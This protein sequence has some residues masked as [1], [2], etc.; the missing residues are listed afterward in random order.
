[1]VDFAA[2]DR[3][4]QGL[5]GRE[6]AIEGADADAGAAR[7]RLEARVRA[8][9]AEHRFRCLEHPLAIANRIGARPSCGRPRMLSHLFRHVI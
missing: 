1:M 4:E 8:A 5:A 3:L 9:G 6:M 7:H 2:I